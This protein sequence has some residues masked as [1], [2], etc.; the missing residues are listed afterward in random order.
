MQETILLGADPEFLILS[1]ENNSNREMPIIP[2]DDVYSEI[3][4]QDVGMVGQ[5]GHSC[6]GEL[7]FSRPFTNAKELTDAT[8]VLLK[9]LVL[10]IDPRLIIVGGSGRYGEAIGGH[11]HLGHATIHNHA[12]YLSDVMDLMIA[13][14]LL[15][16]SDREAAKMRICESCYGKLGSIAVGYRRLEYRPLPS[17]LVSRSYTLAVLTMAEM[18]T[19]AVLNHKLILPTFTSLG[20]KALLYYHLCRTDFFSPLVSRIFKLYRKLPLWQDSNRAKVIAAFFGLLNAFKHTTPQKTWNEEKNILGRWDLKKENLKVA[21]NNDAFVPIVQV[22]WPQSTSTHGRLQGVIV[23]TIEQMQSWLKFHDVALPSVEGYDKSPILAV[24]WVPNP[25]GLLQEPLLVIC[26]ENVGRNGCSIHEERF[27]IAKDELLDREDTR[28]YP[29]SRLF[30]NTQAAIY[31]DNEET[32]T[33]F[34]PARTP[35]GVMY[36]KAEEQND[37]RALMKNL[38]V[39]HKSTYG[40]RELPVA[41]LIIPTSPRYGLG[42]HSQGASAREEMTRY[43]YRIYCWMAELLDDAS[44]F[45]GLEDRSVGVLGSARWD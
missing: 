6:V 10:N 24:V 13:I 19:D 32:V 4:V 44:E 39:L 30:P 42:E 27:R 11:I 36:M 18:I 5:D 7:R 16:L 38:G 41:F 37:L 34:K 9:N 45:S 43:V 3:I 35:L 20:D 21:E 28:I 26:K 14:P 12:A 2:A 17:W 29:R 1:P 8:G 22:F 25:A 15:L 33:I 31:D 23:R 40:E